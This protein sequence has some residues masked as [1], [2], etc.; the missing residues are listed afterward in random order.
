[1]SSYD[2]HGNI[3]EYFLDAPLYMF[4]HFIVDVWGNSPNEE[5]LLLGLA[6]KTILEHPVVEGEL[7]KGES[8]YPDDK[9]NIYPNLQA[10]FNDVLSFWRSLNEEVRPSIYYYVRFRIESERKTSEVR[11]VTGRDFTVR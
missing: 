11:R 8:F 10:D 9:I 7:L 5:N 1:V 6:I 3:V 2:R 4:A